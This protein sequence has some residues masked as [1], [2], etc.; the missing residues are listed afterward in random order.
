M[1]I[2][3]W[4]QQERKQSIANVMYCLLD[5]GDEVIVFTPYWVSYLALIELAEA[6][7]VFV[8]GALD[9]DFKPT[10]QQLKDAISSKTKAVIFSSPNNPTGSAFTRDELKEFADILQEQPNIYVISDEIYE[11]INFEGAH[12]SIASF[13]GMK[14]NTIVVNGFSKGFAMT[15]WRLG[16]I[17]APEWIAKAATKMQGQITSGTSSISQRAALAA[18]EG[19]RS[20]TQA[21][22][23]RLQVSTGVGL[24]TS[25]RNSRRQG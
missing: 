16:Y 24:V 13:P 5:P 8:E 7:A 6:K 9:N 2:T 12:E 18:I 14:D 25:K 11:Y 19:D 4:C 20:D 23:E 10:A 1:R 15:G 17:A 3:S 22:V 21:M